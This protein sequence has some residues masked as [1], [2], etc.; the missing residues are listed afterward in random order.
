MILKVVTV[1]VLVL[2]A[3]PMGG[4]LFNRLPL[5]DPPGFGPRIKTYLTKNVAETLPDSPF[6]ELRPRHYVVSAQRL[7]V[8][9]EKACAD[10]GWR[11]IAVRPREGVVSAVVRTRLWKFKDD[12]EARV[13][14][15]PGES[16][17]LQIRSS[18]RI[19]RGDLGAN[20]RHV[21]DLFGAV[22]SVLAGQS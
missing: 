3:L 21:L 12:V 10:L 9:V 13:T 8:A 7:L 15:S 16:A 22:E 11:S 20:T 18:S 2:I 14:P 1:T 19:G 6:P 17:W 4:I 5:Y